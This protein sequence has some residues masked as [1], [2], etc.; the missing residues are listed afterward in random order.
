[1]NI[2]KKF[3]LA[4]KQKD[5]YSL[6]ECLSIFVVGYSIFY[7]IYGK[8]GLVEFIP[9]IRE[10]KSGWVFIFEIILNIVIF[11]IIPIFFFIKHSLRFSRQERKRQKLSL[12]VPKYIL[13]TYIF[14]LL[15]FF[16]F[17]ILPRLL[18]HK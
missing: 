17:I 2:F 6:G 3:K 10:F 1:M 9:D 11:G 7:A 13:L 8:V 15:V 5:Y 18:D 14:C 4:I 16:L 12:L